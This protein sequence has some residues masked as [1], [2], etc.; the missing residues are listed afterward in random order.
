LQPTMSSTIRETVTL[1]LLF[2]SW[3]STIYTI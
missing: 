3:F 1:V 2:L